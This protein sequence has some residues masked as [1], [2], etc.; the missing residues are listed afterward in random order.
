MASFLA[1]RGAK[2]GLQVGTAYLFSNEIVDTQ[3]M[4]KQYQDIIIEK[5]ETVVIGR[6]L[7]LASRTAPTQ[8]ARKMVEHEAQMIVNKEGLIQRKRSF[9]KRNIG[10]LLIGAKG[11][12][13]DFKRKGE[14]HYTWFEGAEHREKGNFLVGDSLAFFKG[15][16]SIREIHDQYFDGKSQ[17]F[18][19]INQLEIFFQPE[20]QN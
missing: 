19:H 12:L 1:A 13:P 4:K 18:K 9:E 10:S 3:S 11:F 2:I 16:V 17:L 15:P 6:T 7:G 14:E 20:Q 8:F 5:D